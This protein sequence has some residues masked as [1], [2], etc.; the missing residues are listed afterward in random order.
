MSA[1]SI[2]N[3]VLLIISTLLAALAHLINKRNEEQKNEI[4]ALRKQHI[5]DSA[6]LVEF[7][8]RVAREYYDSRRVDSLFEV[9]RKTM[10]EGFT[11]VEKAIESLQGRLNG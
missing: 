1:D 10:A 8:L 11:R 2:L 4:D 6:A 3:V 7:E 5:E 9:N